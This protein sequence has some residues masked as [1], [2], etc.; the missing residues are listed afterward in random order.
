[1]CNTAVAGPWL[2]TGGKKN[3][4]IDKTLL[5]VRRGSS[6]PLRM[7]KQEAAKARDLWALATGE[8]DDSARDADT[9]LRR[10]FHPAASSTC[11]PRGLTRERPRGAGISWVNL[12]VTE[13]NYLFAPP[14]IIRILH[15]Y[16]L[17]TSWDCYY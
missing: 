11:Q 6:L 13:I 10:N 4:L 15:R 14:S 2:L 16:K 8:D 17:C 3:L 5:L 1:M 9:R 12:S 7:Q